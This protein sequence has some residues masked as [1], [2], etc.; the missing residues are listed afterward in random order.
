MTM[1]AHYLWN[2]WAVLKDRQ[3]PR[4]HLGTIDRDTPE[5]GDMTEA[6]A[7]TEAL[8]TLKKVGSFY[9]YGGKS[10]AASDFSH[11]EVELAGATNRALA[12]PEPDPDA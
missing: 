11:L 6:D 5:Y 2:V 1:N 12:R 3:E 9:Q 8:S 4:R 10:L 7:M